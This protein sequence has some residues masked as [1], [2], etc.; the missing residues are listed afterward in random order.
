MKLWKY[1]VVNKNK[2]KQLLCIRFPLEELLLKVVCLLAVR[3][4]NAILYPLLMI[5]Y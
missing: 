4:L 1:F 2:E 3:V 5:P